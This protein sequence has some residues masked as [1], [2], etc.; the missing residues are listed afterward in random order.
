MTFPVQLK[1]QAPLTLTMPL[2]NNVVSKMKN[3]TALAC[4]LIEGLSYR[5]T[6]RHLTN[7]MCN[8]WLNEVR[9]KA[10]PE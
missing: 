1:H 3:H 10:R 2:P 4:I 5:K 9:M 8:I 7:N 6:Y